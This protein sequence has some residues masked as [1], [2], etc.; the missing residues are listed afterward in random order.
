[1][2]IA[3]FYHVPAIIVFVHDINAYHRTLACPFGNVQL[4]TG[5]LA[6]IISLF[7]L[8]LRVLARLGSPLLLHPATG[9]AWYD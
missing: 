9:S 1:M 7:Q 3:R 5:T 4:E 2:T 8:I 6:V